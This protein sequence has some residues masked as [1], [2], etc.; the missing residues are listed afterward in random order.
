MGL[1][2]G[3]L[4]S[5]SRSVDQLCMETL[6][7]NAYNHRESL[8]IGRDATLKLSHRWRNMCMTT[9]PTSTSMQKLEAQSPLPVSAGGTLVL[10]ISTANLEKLIEDSNFSALVRSHGELADGLLCIMPTK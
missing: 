8:V 6:K 2:L 4:C 7:H 3:I 9:H 1:S 5:T 10:E